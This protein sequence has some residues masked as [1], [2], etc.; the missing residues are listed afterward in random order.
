M[1][2]TE[3][4]NQHVKKKKLTRKMKEN[5]NN[6]SN[7]N[8]FICKIVLYNS[9]KNTVPK[10]KYRW[11]KIYNKKLD[12]L[13]SERIYVSK[14][15]CCI[16]KNIINNFSSYTLTSEEDYALLFSLDQHIPTKRN[17]SNITSFFYHIQTHSKNLDQ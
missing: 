12:T 7:K 9:I 2:D 16:V 11:D 5:T 10:E 6:T 13:H 8:S 17:I 14:P 4:R 15:K 3:I 1:L